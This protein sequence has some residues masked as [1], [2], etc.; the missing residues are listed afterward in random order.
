MLMFVEILK[1]KQ[2]AQPTEAKK[3]KLK[4]RITKRW[5]EPGG[6]DTIWLLIIEKVRRKREEETLR[7]G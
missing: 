2:R 6:S 1:K 3:I 4:T 7:K 5:C